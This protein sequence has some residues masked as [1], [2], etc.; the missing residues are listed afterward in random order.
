MDGMSLSAAERLQTLA[1]RCPI[2]AS[3]AADT[4]GVTGSFRVAADACVVMQCQECTTVYLSPVP[5]DGPV[6]PPG[7]PAAVLTRRRVERWTR[8]LPPSARILCFD[9]GI[10]ERL[11]SHA[12]TRGRSWV[13][14]SADQASASLSAARY[15]LILLANALE[16]ARDPGRFLRQAASRLAD[17]GRIIAVVH[18]AGSA[19][20]GSFGGRHWSGYRFPGSR[21]CFTPAALGRL[22]GHAGLRLMVGQTLF[23]PQAWLESTDNWLRDWGTGVG[24]RR[25]F[26]GRWLVPRAISCLVE[27]VAAMRGRGSMLAARLEMQ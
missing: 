9:G 19:A 23:H 2:C 25:L 16:A 17:G 11:S 26:T 10:A 7:F 13:V 15:D 1:L 18:N 14:E 27:V 4:L 22:A 8:G 20:F 24:T 21:Q 5:V 6:L 3:D 12:R